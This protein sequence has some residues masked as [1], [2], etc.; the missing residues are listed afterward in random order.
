MKPN[1]TYLDVFSNYFGVLIPIVMTFIS[2]PIFLKALGPSAYGVIGISTMVQTWVMLLNSSLSPVVG[3]SA[4]QASIG[5]I[6]WIEV[7]KLCR[8]IDLLLIIFMCIAL[9]IIFLFGETIAYYWFGSENGVSISELST[10]IMLLTLTTLI[11]LASSI[12]RGI[13]Q[14]L[15][16]QVWLNIQ[17]SIFNIFRFSIAMFIAISTKKIVDVFFYWLI[18]SIFEWFS[19]NKKAYS[20][21]PCKKNMFFFDVRVLFNQRKIAFPLLLSGLAYTLITNFD[22]AM[23]SKK[24]DLSMYGFFSIVTLLAGSV[25]LVSTPIV[26][27]FQPK[28]IKSKLNN[29]NKGS[30]SDSFASLFKLTTI[31]IG[32]FVIPVASVIIIHPEFVLYGWTGNWM[33]ADKTKN[34]LSL[35]TLGNV[36]AVFSSM[37]YLLQLAYGNVKWHMVGYVILIVILIPLFYYTINYMQLEYVAFSWFVVNFIYFFVWGSIIFKIII[38][39][40]DFGW[41][42]FDVLLPISIGL[43]VSSFF[44]FFI[45][46]SMSRWHVVFYLFLC[47]ISVFLSCIISYPL[48]RRYII[49]VIKR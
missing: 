33:L 41:F 16:H 25:I 18:L 22:K 1:K 44:S 37:F 49:N 28:I 7:F 8:T 36:F 39:K 15:D 4:T 34:I 12:N 27:V 10:C 2:V 11:R 46:S 48:S 3:R 21:I 5:D 9:V 6:E 43:A 45:S 38:K 32:L 42:V 40:I 23:L 14:H 31:L 29:I 20:L 35:Y 47:G 13:I 30:D 26:Q 24:L 19:V 17:M